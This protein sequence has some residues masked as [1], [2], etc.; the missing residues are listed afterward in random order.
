[1][2]DHTPSALPGLD[3][4]RVGEGYGAD[5]CV[6]SSKKQMTGPAILVPT[7]RSSSPSSTMR[8]W[9]SA[10]YPLIGIVKRANGPQRLKP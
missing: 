4:L 3:G 10:T 9:T 1:M 6:Q 5:R 2:H 8:N 7:R